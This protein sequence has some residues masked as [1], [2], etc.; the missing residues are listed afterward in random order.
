VS[1][2]IEA[3]I[4]QYQH[5]PGITHVTL[6]QSVQVASHIGIYSS[7]ILYNTSD[8]YIEKVGKAKFSRLTETKKLVTPSWKTNQSGGNRRNH[9][10]SPKNTA[11]FDLIENI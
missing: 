5:I 11:R 3:E 7:S 2:M 6:Q 8:R 1:D 4:V 10:S 9:V